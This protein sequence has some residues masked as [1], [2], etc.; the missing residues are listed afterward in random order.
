MLAFQQ[1]QKPIELSNLNVLGFGC[2]TGLLTQI[3]AAHKKS[4]VAL[5]SYE[6]MIQVLNNKNLPNIQC[7][8][9]FLTEQGIQEHDQLKTYLT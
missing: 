6:K 5:D 8:T 4:I 7:L 2:G 1:L 3:M 9:G